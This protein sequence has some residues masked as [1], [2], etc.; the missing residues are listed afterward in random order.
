MD[1]IL[2]FIINILKNN[3][4]AISL[5]S[6]QIA[7]TVV[8]FLIARYLTVYDYGLFSSYKNIAMF[9][10]IFANLGFNEYI[11]ISSKAN[12]KEV[13]QKISLFM[14]NAVFV[15]VLTLL[16]SAFFRMENHYLFCLV[17]FRSFFDA[18]FFALILPYF[19]ASKK[20]NIIALINIIYSIGI[21]II[22]FISYVFKLSLIN[23]LYLNIALGVL[24]FIQCSLYSN[25]KY[26]LVVKHILR[27][28]KMLDKSIFAYAG[29]I[30]AFYL[31][32]QIPSLYVSSFLNKTS[33]ALYFAALTISSVINLFIA[34]LNQK[35]VPELISINKKEAKV[36]L[37]RN[38]LLLLNVN[39]F[40]LFVFAVCGKFLLQIFYGQTYYENAYLLLLILSMSNIWLALANVYGAYITASG[41]QKYK[42][43]KQ[44][45]AIIISIST[46]LFTYKFG[47]YS[48]ALAYF[49][50]A[51]YIGI[52]YMQKTKQLLK[53]NFSN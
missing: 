45:I 9:C 13:R 15:L 10:L 12:I 53:E 11:L 7:G 27:Y 26:V 22:A 5:Y 51:G 35:I 19:Q 1:K 17:A 46:L 16:F 47:I 31:Y 24:N 40:I 44:I 37:K 48:A 18:I 14:I 32:S 29:T 28:I 33:A 4:Y 38:F 43:P 25:I 8:L 21:I 34:A 23:F 6:R 50:S 36:I 39:I 20:F 49:L 42:I 41:N 3:F 30:I 2:N 52:T